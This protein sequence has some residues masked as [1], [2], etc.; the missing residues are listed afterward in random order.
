MEESRQVMLGED[1]A[2]GGDADVV[3]GA[4][5]VERTTEEVAV[6]V[7]VGVMLERV[8]ETEEGGMEDDEREVVE[9]K[10]DVGAAGT[11]GANAVETTPFTTES[12]PGT[13]PPRNPSCLG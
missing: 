13:H 10:R 12:K 3:V 2:V 4:V 11:K 7:V 1:V 8:E 9:I 6:D 5:V